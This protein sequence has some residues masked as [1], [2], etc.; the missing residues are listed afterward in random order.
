M[1]TGSADSRAPY[2]PDEFDVLLARIRSGDD[3]ASTELVSRYER[4]V[5]RAVRARLSNRMRRYLDSI[6]VVQSVHRSL[7]I[8]VRDQRYQFSHPAQLM[9]LAMV[10]VQRKVA[11][12]WR[13]VKH[14]PAESLDQALSQ[15]QQAEP[16]QPEHCVSIEANELLSQILA[17]L[18]E[19][20]RRLVLLKLD[21]HSSAE[22]GLKLGL[23]SAFI[24]M[25]WSRLRTNL[26][27]WLE[28]TGVTD[29]A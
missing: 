22:I 6:D 29:P 8:G 14:Y 5:I 3:A 11:R 24:R 13:K 25:R 1:E 23:D 12:Q 7:L 18:G 17:R 20:D 16:R 27:Q 28:R 21:G 2:P 26:R 15:K 9:A 10:L 4:A 19:V